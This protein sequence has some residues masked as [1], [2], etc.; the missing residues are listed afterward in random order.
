ME[1]F[2]IS[3]AQKENVSE[4]VKIH[5][6]CVQES[7]SRLYSTVIIEDWLKQINVEN[8]LSQFKNSSWIVMKDNDRLVGFAQYSI[9][10]GIIYQIQIAPEY[11]KKGYGKKL[12]NYIE[13]DFTRERQT[14]IMLNATLNATAF[15][16]RL[17][18]KV[19][20]SIN[21]GNI[22]MVKMEKKL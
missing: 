8:V 7:N 21:F 20:E 12:Y 19:L 18:F 3:K 2:L 16:E 9:K 17:G 14:K 13:K 1:S 5:K 15:Y 4:I 22:E 11:Q 10:D 6:K